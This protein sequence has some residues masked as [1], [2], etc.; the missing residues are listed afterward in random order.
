MQRE[1]M[2]QGKAALARAITPPPDYHIK[3]YSLVLC[4]STLVAW[5]LLVA[6]ILKGW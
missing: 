5:A 3:R 6:V 1:T 4:F 2:H